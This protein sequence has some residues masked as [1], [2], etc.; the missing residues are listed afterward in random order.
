MRQQVDLALIVDADV[1]VDH[2]MWVKVADL[3]CYIQNVAD[4]ELLESNQV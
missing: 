3:P 2:V 1:T 4:T